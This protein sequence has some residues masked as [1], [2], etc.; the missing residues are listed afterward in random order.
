MQPPTILIVEDE[1][2]LSAALATL[3]K[4]MG[5]NPI[6]EPSG[7]RAIEAIRS[8]K[9]DA[10]VLDIGLPD[11][12]GL[13]VLR[14][15]D[16]KPQ[17]PV[18]V[19][20]AHGNLENAIAAKQLGVAEY[21]TKPLDLRE[22]EE[23]LGGLLKHGDPSRSV[24]QSDEKAE[25]TLIGA[26]PAMQPV[27]RDIAH[28]CSM[29]VPVVISGATGVGKSLAARVIH[30]NSNYAS[31][32]LAMFDASNEARA[33][34]KFIND[35]E[36][37]G[38][39][40]AI[41]E[42]VSELNL[43]QQAEFLRL[44]E[45]NLDAGSDAN[46][47]V[48]FISTAIGDLHDA[49]A[50]G[51]FRESL[52]YRLRGLNIHMPALAERAEDIPALAAFFLGRACS[53]RTISLSP[54]VVQTLKTHAWPGNVL[55]LRN[56]IDYAVAVCGGSRILIQHLPASVSMPTEGDIE[57]DELESAISRWVERQLTEGGRLP[58]YATLIDHVESLL[59]AK[60][61]CKFDHRPT[62]LA[63]AL[64]MNRTTLRKRCARLG[65]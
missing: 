39:G 64:R 43:E 49:V 41:I 7:S 11:M 15:F 59:L 21:L 36:N 17:V 23:A 34:G 26:A 44:I 30:A 10:I 5:A 4:R 1:H 32:A 53:D 61:L 57:T 33:I 2:A 62:R 45:A 42:N 38:G 50:G 13:D 60:L 35:L 29:T 12:N 48:R 14:E 16:G 31:K 24:T 58:S 40:T 18:L 47:R 8:I 37:S 25:T 65:L 19:I 27:F 63:E 55:E 20:T 6:V 46:S 52:Y 28:A 51:E 9:P 22:F 54:E 56:A 3:T